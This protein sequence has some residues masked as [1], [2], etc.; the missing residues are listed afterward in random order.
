[1]DILLRFHVSPITDK[2]SRHLMSFICFLM[3]QLAITAAG[4]S[5]NNQASNDGNRA[6][7]LAF[8]YLTMRNDVPCV[9][10]ALAA[11]AAVGNSNTR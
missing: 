6:F 9:I 8:Y 11:L 7:S 10:P 5:R 1:M 4:T 3:V 2:E